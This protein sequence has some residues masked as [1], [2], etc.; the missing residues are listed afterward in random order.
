MA[1]FNNIVK[2]NFKRKIF[3]KKF[4]KKVIYTSL[5][6]NTRISLQERQIIYIKYI[7]YNNNYSISRLKNYCFITGHSRA[8]YRCVQLNRHHFKNMVLNGS[9]PG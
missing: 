2:D 8:I 5:L 4:L 3:V 1:T 6:Y 7:K 9:I